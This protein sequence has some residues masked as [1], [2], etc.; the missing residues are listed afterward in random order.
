MTQYITESVYPCM[1][2][3]HILQNCK[4]NTP[5]PTFTGHMTYN[6]ESHDMA[7]PMW[8]ETEKSLSIIRETKKAEKCRC[9]SVLP[10]RDE[11]EGILEAASNITLERAKNTPTEGSSGNR[12]LCKSGESCSGNKP[13]YNVNH[14]PS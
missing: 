11:V 3:M 14:H 13:A 1:R 5:P 12:N 6:K 9:I 2:K 7:W 8:T 10:S 4:R